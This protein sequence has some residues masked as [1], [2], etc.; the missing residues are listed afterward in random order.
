MS[1]LAGLLRLPTG[2]ELV[3]PEGSKIMMYIS[4]LWNLYLPGLD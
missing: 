1:M 3:E 2:T 4:F